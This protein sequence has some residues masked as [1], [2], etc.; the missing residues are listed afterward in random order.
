MLSSGP[1]PPFWKQEDIQNIGPRYHQLYITVSQLELLYFIFI[2]I[3]Y[4]GYI[5]ALILVM[6]ISYYC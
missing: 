6:A 5:C 2:F 3:F 1:P 4:L